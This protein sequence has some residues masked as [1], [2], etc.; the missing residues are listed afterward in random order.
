MLAEWNGS[1]VDPGIGVVALANE[2]EFVDPDLAWQRKFGPALAGDFERARGVLERVNLGDGEMRHVRP[3]LVEG[4]N[5]GVEL[6]VQFTQTVS[7]ERHA[8]KNSGRLGHEVFDVPERDLERVGL[9]TDALDER[10]GFGF[11]TGET[12]RRQN[13]DVRGKMSVRGMDFAAKV[14]DEFSDGILDIGDQRVLGLR[15]HG[16]NYSRCGEVRYN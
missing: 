9:L 3:L 4:E 15:D 14:L 10:N 2:G 8:D 1:E 13:A 12:A 6:I 5:A 7:G 16:A 11:G